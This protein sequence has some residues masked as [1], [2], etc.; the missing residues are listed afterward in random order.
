LGTEQVF[1]APDGVQQYTTS[2][3]FGTTAEL[4]QANQ[5]EREYEKTEEEEF[6]S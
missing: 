4:A 2:F 5:N 6:I 1:Q 3:P